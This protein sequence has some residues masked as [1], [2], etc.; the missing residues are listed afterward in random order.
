MVLASQLGIG[1][2]IKIAKDLY[3]VENVVKVDGQKA[4]SFIKCKLRHLLTAESIEKNFKINQEVDEVVLE[5]KKLEY[6]YAEGKGYVFLDLGTLDLV[7]VEG[8]I[9]GKK[10][11]YLKE[12]TEVKGS[13]FGSTI[14]SIELPQFLELMVASVSTSEGSGKQGGGGSARIAKLETGSKIEVPP[15]VDVGDIIKI[16]T[17]TEEYIQ[18]V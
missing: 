4:N 16:D 13:G 10:I 17:K 6:L 14:F 1:T 11:H 8:H 12:G 9:V 7:T 3:R 5:D 2:T 18:R 15:F